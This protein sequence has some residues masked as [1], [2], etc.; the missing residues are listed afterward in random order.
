[1]TRDFWSQGFD[2]E[3]VSRSTSVCRRSLGFSEFS[4]GAGDILASAIVLASVAF[5]T[6]PAAETV[7]FDRAPTG[8]PPAGSTAGQTGS[9]HANWTVV[10]DDTAPSRP[11]VL[12]QSGQATYPVCIK[13]A[14][15]IR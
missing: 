13:D 1:M 14:P 5:A 3:A 8:T 12:K 9:G 10:A 7:S 4:L 6:A 2:P 15:S 11:S